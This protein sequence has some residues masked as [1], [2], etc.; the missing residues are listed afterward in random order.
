MVYIRNAYELQQYKMY[1][2]IVMISDID[3]LPPPLQFL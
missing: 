2:K 1:N 3:V